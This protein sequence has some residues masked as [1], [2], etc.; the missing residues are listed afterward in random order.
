ML[1]QQR[2]RKQMVQE[3]WLYFQEFWIWHVVLAEKQCGRGEEIQNIKIFYVILLQMKFFITLFWNL[4]WYYFKNRVNST[5]HE[6]F[7][8]VLFFLSWWSNK[9]KEALWIDVE[10][11]GVINSIHYWWKMII[12]TLQ[13]IG[14]FRKLLAKLF[15]NQEQNSETVVT[16]FATSSSNFFGWPLQNYWVLFWRLL[17]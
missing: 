4:V 11:N 3:F 6:M 1:P 5:F 9:D 7:R 10:W 12:L 17:T 13:V 8:K 2:G 14:I 16:S 15:G